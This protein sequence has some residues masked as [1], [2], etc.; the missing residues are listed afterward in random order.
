MAVSMGR[1]DPLATSGDMKTVPA[2]S[3]SSSSMTTPTRMP[4]GAYCSMPWRI[5]AKSTSSIMTTKRKSTATA[6]T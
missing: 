6:P 5:S 1:L 3:S 4:M 2:T